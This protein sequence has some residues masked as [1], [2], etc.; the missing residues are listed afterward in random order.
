MHKVTGKVLL[1]E[2]GVGIPNLV[3]TVYDIDSNTL[4][5]ETFQSKQASLVNFWE[6]L[7]GER[8]GSVLTDRDGTFALEYD[9]REF[10]EKRPDLLLFVTG[11]EGPGLDGCSPVLHVSCGIRQHAGRIESYL[12]RLTAEE[13]KGAGVPLPSVPLANLPQSKG[14]PKRLADIEQRKEATYKLL[15]KVRATWSQDDSP[16]PKISEIYRQKVKALQEAEA[17]NRI[18]TN[19]FRLGLPMISTSGDGQGR[20]AFDGEAKKWFM[21]R[22][23]ERTEIKFGGIVS[24]DEVKPEEKPAAGINVVLDEQNKEFRVVISRAPTRLCAAGN[25]PGEL[26][27]E[28]FKRRFVRAK[29]RSKRAEP[30]SSDEVHGR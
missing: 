7:Q 1:H 3:V 4:P 26:F 21:Q 13:L 27:I 9:D 17:K 2:T 18:P 29:T 30:A 14:I 12:I 11:P 5:R 24:A 16:P 6:Q 25:S 22:G 10:E 20:M 23:G 15:E 8:L 28:T 19:G